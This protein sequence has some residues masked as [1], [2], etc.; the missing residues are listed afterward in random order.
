MAN[1][2]EEGTP[3]TNNLSDPTKD[4]T[5]RQL[6]RIHVKHSEIIPKQTS[7][8]EEAVH[9]ELATAV[10]NSSKIAPVNLE[11]SLTAEQSKEK[12]DCPGSPWASSKELYKPLKTHKSEVPIM[13]NKFCKQYSIDAWLKGNIVKYQQKLSGRRSA[14]FK[15]LFLCLECYTCAIIYIKDLT[16]VCRLLYVCMCTVNMGS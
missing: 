3:L 11:M 1:L 13:H 2:L 12:L 15:F 9:K 8:D 6:Q 10:A 4:V 16:D 5:S 14:D 7:V